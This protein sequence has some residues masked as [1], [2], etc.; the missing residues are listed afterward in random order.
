MRPG[1]PGCVSPRRF[2]VGGSTAL[3]GRASAS[4]G[5]VNW[6]GICIRLYV[7]SRRLC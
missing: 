6:I 5:R 1:L 7:F 4:G 2:G 3:R